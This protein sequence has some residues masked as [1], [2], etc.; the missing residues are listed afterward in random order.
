MAE[1]VH[2]RIG[3]SGS[4]GIIVEVVLES[5]CSHEG[6]RQVIQDHHEMTKIFMIYQH[7]NGDGE[8]AQERVGHQID[9]KQMFDVDA[10]FE[11]KIALAGLNSHAAQHHHDQ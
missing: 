3:V 7:L 5:E 1:A 10:Q 6:G 4:S 8:Y 11:P 2:V 9:A